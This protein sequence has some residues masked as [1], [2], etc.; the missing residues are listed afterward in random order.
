MAD[1][2]LRR[3]GKCTKCKELVSNVDDCQ[4]CAHR[5]PLTANKW[6]EIVDGKRDDRPFDEKHDEI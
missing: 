6:R 1:R 3:S 2:K 4:N 5:N